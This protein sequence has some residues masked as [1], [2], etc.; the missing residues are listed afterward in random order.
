MNEELFHMSP[1]QL[2]SATENDEL[3]IA[4]IQR[5]RRVLEGGGS[6]LFGY[7][8]NDPNRRII[9]SLEEFERIIPK[10]KIEAQQDAS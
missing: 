6:V 1:T 3:R 4:S 2:D 10:P 9:S 7:G 5:G 8:P